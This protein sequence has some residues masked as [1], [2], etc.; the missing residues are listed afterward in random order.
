VDRAAINT[1][2]YMLVPPFVEV[3]RLQKHALVCYAQQWTSAMQKLGDAK[4]GP[5]LPAHSTDGDA[6]LFSCGSAHGSSRLNAQSGDELEPR[7]SA[8][9]GGVARWRGEKVN[10]C[11]YMTIS[12]KACHWSFGRRSTPLSMAT[13]THVSGDQDP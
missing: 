6:D 3:N 5:L 13:L 7:K 4:A 10:G 12:C 8:N 11:L 1:M 9:V 2:L